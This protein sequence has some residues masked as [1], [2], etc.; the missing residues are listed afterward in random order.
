MANTTI[1]VGEGTVHRGID[2]YEIPCNHVLP[3]QELGRLH[4][5][6]DVYQE[7]AEIG[8]CVAQAGDGHSGPI[9]C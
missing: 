7:V 9:C 6:M 2:L 4:Q 5:Y 1:S 3:L 8:G